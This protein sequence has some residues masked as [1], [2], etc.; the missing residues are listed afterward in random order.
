MTKINVVLKT[1]QPATLLDANSQITSF[2][3]RDFL[4]KKVQ[5]RP[6][7]CS[8]SK[9][10]LWSCVILLPL[11]QKRFRNLIGLQR[12][13]RVCRNKARANIVRDYNNRN[14]KR[15][16]SRLCLSG[17]PHAVS[18]VSVVYSHSRGVFILPNSFAL[19]EERYLSLLPS[20]WS[21]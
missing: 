14:N 5:L 18:F 12:R 2:I 11:A 7:L 16:S 8:Y 13:R 10:C 1:N 15:G 17:S 3:I 20:S 6:L 21:D 4:T 19:S 9:M